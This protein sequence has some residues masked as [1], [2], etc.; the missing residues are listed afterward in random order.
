MLVQY[1]L[2]HYPLSYDLNFETVCREADIDF[3]LFGCSFNGVTNHTHAYMLRIEQVEVLMACME[4]YATH[5]TFHKF[6][7]RQLQEALNDLLHVALL[8]DALESA[9]T[10]R[11]S[12][13]LGI[14]L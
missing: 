12:A 7:Y 10:L 14:D 9:C 3:A 8:N 5:E 13:S 11:D 6:T 1:R 4:G 2:P